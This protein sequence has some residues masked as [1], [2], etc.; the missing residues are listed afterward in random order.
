MG[1][2]TSWIAV[3]GK[4]S[5]AVC[6]AL[7]LV[8]TGKTRSTSSAPYSAAT[9]PGGW[10]LVEA[11]ADAE[12]AEGVDLVSLSAGCEIVTHAVNNGG[13]NSATGWHDGRRQWLIDAYEELE[14]IG[15]LPPEAEAVLAAI[16]ESD[17][18]DEWEFDP[19]IGLT[20]SLVGYEY[21]S[22]L[23]EGAFE[24]LDHPEYRDL[25]D[26]AFTRLTEALDAAGFDLVAVEEVREQCY[27]S[28]RF[29]NRG[30]AVAGM[31]PDLHVS[32]A[33]H[34]HGGAVIDGSVWVMAQQVNDL[35]CELPAQAW[36]DR[37]SATW[38]RSTHLTVLG[39]DR[40][41]SRL[42]SP[43]E[44][45]RSVQEF[46]SF[47][48]REVAAWFTTVDETLGSLIAVVRSPPLRNTWALRPTVVACLLNGRTDR[49]AALMNWYIA[50]GNYPNRDSAQRITAFD[51]ALQVRF[52]QY[53]GLRAAAAPDA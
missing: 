52:P 46:V 20:A 30:I 13:G 12:W 53:A 4:S 2:N 37:E 5:E 50:A 18:P 23:T 16:T 8:G 41:P 28:A 36:L 3:R 9:L 22:S 24:I 26:L 31:T 33:R 39:R 49:A 47:A 43:A 19:V 48:E 11:C 40:E 15:Q 51:D 34:Q 32:I 35:L 29:V 10:F 21:G 1:Y 42:G 38:L 44:V 7:G 45:E 27:V 17:D 14:I 6:A 25:P